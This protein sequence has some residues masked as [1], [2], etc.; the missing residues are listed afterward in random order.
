[1]HR[2]IRILD[3]IL[4]NALVVLMAALV[5]SVSWQVMRTCHAG[6]IR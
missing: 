6:E 4:K 2:L 3:V 1:M 5:I